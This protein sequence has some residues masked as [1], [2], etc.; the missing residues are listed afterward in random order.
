VLFFYGATLIG[1]GMAVGGLFGTRLAAP[2][3]AVV[4][5][6]TWF[7]QLLGPLLN[8]PDFI[9]QLAITNHYGQPMVGIGTGAASSLRR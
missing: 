9:Q 4:V 3:A 6:V 5:L 8:L 7:V 1:I 2:V